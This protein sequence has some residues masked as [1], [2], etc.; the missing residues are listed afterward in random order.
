MYFE[1][2]FAPVWQFLELITFV[3]RLQ[4]RRKVRYASHS[5]KLIDN[6]ITT[7]VILPKLQYLNM[8][9]QSEN[10]PEAQARDEVS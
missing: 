4:F 5:L 10:I 8:N 1:N 9:S 3:C 2:G 7:I 6:T